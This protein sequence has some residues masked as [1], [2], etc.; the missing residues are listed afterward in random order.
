MKPSESPQKTY[1][2]L[3]IGGG[4]VGTSLARELQS[5]G[6]QVTLLERGSV[7]QACSLGNAGWITPCFAMP[8]PQPGMLL[9]SIGWLLDPQSPLYI[10]PSLDPMLLRWLWRFL[11]SMR[12]DKMLRSIEVLTEVSKYSLKFYEEL[13]HLHPGSG[14]LAFEKRGLLMVS[15]TPDGLRSA[16]SEM[17][18]MAERGIP[19]RALSQDEALEL[20]PTLKPHILGGVYFPEEAQIDPLAATLAITSEFKALGGEVLEKHEVY[21]FELSAQGRIQKVLT[22]QGIF[23]PDLVILASG[24][25]SPEVANKLRLSVPILGGKGYSMTLGAAEGETLTPPS[26]PI[27]IVER[28]IAVTPFPGR[29]RVAGTLELVNNDLSISPRRLAAIHEGAKEFLNLG[30][31]PQVYDVWRG[32]RPCTPDGVPI[33]GFSRRVSNLFYCTG[34]QM[35]GLQSAPGTAK[36]AVDLLTNTPPLTDPTPFDPKRFE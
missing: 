23:E 18:L 14:A 26:K 4:I 20:E 13:A 2:V 30:T 7:G 17:T 11:L 19:G 5:R 24:S 1:D 21:D 31:E 22:T 16:K 9:K 28:K 8:L 15:S 33:V 35:L 10:H 3:I 36:L 34:H 6:R 29:L 12:R 32:L 27:M 25:W